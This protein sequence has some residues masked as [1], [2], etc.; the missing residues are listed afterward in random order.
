[1]DLYVSIVIKLRV[2]RYLFLT[3]FLT[4]VIMNILAGKLLGMEL[5][6]QNINT[7]YRVLIR[8]ISRLE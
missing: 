4:C 2:N 6:G 5:L 1:M 3:C 7:F 8:I